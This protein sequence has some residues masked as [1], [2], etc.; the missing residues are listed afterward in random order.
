MLKCYDMIGDDPLDLELLADHP[1]AFDFYK[2]RLRL[3]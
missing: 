2:D 1:Q 3:S